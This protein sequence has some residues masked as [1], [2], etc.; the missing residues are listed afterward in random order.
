MIGEGNWRA[1]DE[2]SEG[3]QDFSET[4]DAEALAR[5]AAEEL[6]EDLLDPDDEDLAES[7]RPGTEEE[8]EW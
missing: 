8:P 2:D 1:D 5:E 7:A 3:L 4:P 6:E